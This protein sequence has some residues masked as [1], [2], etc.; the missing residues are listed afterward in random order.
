[1]A[2]IKEWVNRLR[3][4]HADKPEDTP[5]ATEPVYRV[6]Y[7]KGDW[8]QIEFSDGSAARK[9]AKTKAEDKFSVEFWQWT[10]TEWRLREH[11]IKGEKVL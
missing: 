10:G 11:W 9:F 6:R 8:E 5:A 4:K 3:R 2:R 1:M 7:C